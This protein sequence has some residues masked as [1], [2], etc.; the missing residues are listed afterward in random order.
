MINPIDRIHEFAFYYNRPQGSEHQGIARLSCP[1][2]GKRGWDR[3]LTEL[4]FGPPSYENYEVLDEGR[5][6]S[7]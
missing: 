5:R 6:T 2:S 7:V 1:H 3:D 4:C